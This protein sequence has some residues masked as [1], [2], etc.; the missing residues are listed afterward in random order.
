MVGAR[1]IPGWMAEEYPFR[2]HRFRCPDGSAMSYVDEGPR[3]DHAVLMVHGN[4]TWSFY[5]RHLIRALAPATRCIAPDHIGMGA[6]AKPAAR[7]YTLASRI[8]DLEAL[9]DSLGLRRLDLVVHDWGGA[10]GLGVAARR[11]GR[12]RRIVA[13]NT[14]AFAS[15]RIPRRIALC[16][17]PGLG[18]LLIRGCNAFAWPA[19]WMTMHRRRLSRLEQRSYLWPYDSWATRVAV[20]AFVR[21]IPMRPSHPSWDALQEVG[22]GLTAFRDR[23]VL[24]VW[25]LRDFCFDRSFLQRWCELL[26][27]TD[28][29]AIADAGHYVLEDAREEAIARLTAFLT[30]T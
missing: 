12:I 6:S 15:S 14:A 20:Y 16:R 9:V 7:A 24:A 17:T 18:A 10:I 5:F 3:A 4:P 29:H 25:G 26:P 21:D 8:S 23:E 19:T 11:P 28:A 22:R 1:D 30:R 27:N 2:P 13:M